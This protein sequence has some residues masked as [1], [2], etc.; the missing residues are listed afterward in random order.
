MK[1]DELRTA[2]EIREEIEAIRVYREKWPCAPDIQNE[3]DAMIRILQWVL[4]E[5]P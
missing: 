5:E 2:A 3:C 4:K 1:K